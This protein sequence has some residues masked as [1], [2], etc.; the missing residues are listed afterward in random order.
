MAMTVR[1]IDRLVG[2]WA[3]K[4]LAW[5]KDNVGLQ[6]GDP[7]QQV[8]SILVALD[9][10]EGIVAEAVRRS[11]D[12]V[13]THHPLLF[14]P[15]R[16]V[17]LETAAGRILRALL[18]SRI[19]LLS[20]HTNLDA[21]P[22]GTNAALARALGLTGV[23]TLYQQHAVARKI[24]TFVPRSHVEAVAEALAGVGA[25]TIGNYHRCSFRA[26]GTGTFFGD[27]DSH[28]RVGAR[29]TLESVSEVRLEMVVD[30][31]NLGAAVSALRRAHPYEEPATDI[32]PLENK[33]ARY[34]MG[35]IGDL[36]RALTV[37]TFLGLVKRRL[38]V[39][40]LRV[41]AFTRKSVKRI[42]VC[43]GAGAELLDEAIRQGAD[44]FVTADVR[45]HV[46]HEAAG[47]IVVVDA[48]HYETE[49]PVVAVLTSRLQKEFHLRRERIQVRS[50]TSPG[51]P[52][53]Y[54]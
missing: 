18:A 44:L 14:R 53:R 9:A 31:W 43:G 21:S 11:V 41:S 7:G 39:P 10:S 45:Y 28:P 19:S 8:R 35:M 42:A 46:F 48:G 47:R 36:R 5:E 15:P 2:S 27:Q 30:E 3:P 54:V 16:S 40:H 34:G 24:V 51:N 37:P 38:G 50:A 17:D 32:Y 1:D 4:S 29:G 52:V 6:C 33:D 49:N 12:L 22:V 25:G 20:A 26:E 13:I 23:S